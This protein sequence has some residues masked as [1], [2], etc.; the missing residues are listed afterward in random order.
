MALPEALCCR[1]AWLVLKITLLQGSWVQLLVGVVV[2]RTR[3]V[4]EAHTKVLGGLVGAEVRP[5]KSEG[6]LEQFQPVHVTGIISFREISVT[7]KDLWQADEEDSQELRFTIRAGGLQSQFLEN[8]THV[9]TYKLVSEMTIII[10][11]AA[12]LGSGYENSLGCCL[13]SGSPLEIILLIAAVFI[14]PIA[15]VSQ[16]LDL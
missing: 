11:T 16:Y 2:L 6:A 1:L 15:A 12:P 9:R 13:I 8:L 3:P 5:N 4:S 7:P 14:L 10:H